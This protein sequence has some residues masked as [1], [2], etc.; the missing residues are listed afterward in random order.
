[1]FFL[2]RYY[3]CALGDGTLPLELFVRW[4]TLGPGDP[5]NAREEGSAPRVV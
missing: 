3:C 4:P 2:F 5:H 1:M